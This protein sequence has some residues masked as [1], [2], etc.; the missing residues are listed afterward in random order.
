VLEK[1]WNFATKAV[2]GG[3]KS[4]P[5]TGSFGLPMYVT[6]GYRFEDQEHAMRLFNMEEEGHL[7][8]RISNPTVEVFEKAVA[9]CEG[10]VDAVATSSG[11]AALTHLLLCLCSA[12]DHVVVATKSYGGTV[13]LVKNLM[14]R[15]GISS[16]FVDTDD[17]EAVRNSIRPNTRC[18]V[19][20]TIGNPCLNVAPLEELAAIT[21]EHHIPLVVDNTFASPALCRPKEWGANVVIHSV[22]KY[23]SGHGQIIGGVIVD[24]GNMDWGASDKWPA[25]T[26]PDPSYHGVVF[27]E[28]FGPAALAAKI[29]VSILRD[30]GGCLSPFNALM[31]KTGLSTLHLRMER[32]SSNALSVARF[33]EEHPMVQWVSYPALESSPSYERAQKYLPN[34]AGGMVAFCIKGGL[35][36]GKAFMGAL[37]LFSCVANLGD[38]RSMAIHPASTTHGQLTPEER[39]ACGIDEGLVRLSVGIEDI[40]DILEDLDKALSKAQQEAGPNARVSG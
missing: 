12:G 39:K 2:H 1:K 28:K 25:L 35:E 9:Q 30:A 38:V 36:A 3:W 26:E 29:K 24:C 15:F 18:V 33:L 10:G 8:S 16:S 20:E 13:T 40:E 31:A 22:T 21:R 19:T 23:I 27:T 37:E 6:A 14:S 34:G 11:Q 17:V 4:D 32:H 7:Y 5:A